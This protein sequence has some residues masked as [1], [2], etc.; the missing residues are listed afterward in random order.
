[1]G[2]DFPNIVQ[3]VVAGA[4]GRPHPGDFQSSA[5]SAILALGDNPDILPRTPDLRSCPLSE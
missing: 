1:M 4:R 5:P 2:E 3:L